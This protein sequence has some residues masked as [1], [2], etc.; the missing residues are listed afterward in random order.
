MNQNRINKYHP[1]DFG[2]AGLRRY[3]LKRNQ[4]S[5]PT[6]YLDKLWALVSEQTWVNPAEKHE[7]GAAPITDAVWWIVLLQSS[8]DGNLPKQPVTVSCSVR[9][10]SF[11]KR[12]EE[13]WK[14]L[15]VPVSWSLKATQGGSLNAN[16]N[17][18]F[19]IPIYPLIL[20]MW[21]LVCISHL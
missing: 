15:Q 21:N 16:I 10:E 17:F 3:H 20:I 6:V 18:P 8:G 14:M 12:T 19:Y 7:A 11:S 1:G 2:R 4:S 9:A 13:T 5:Y